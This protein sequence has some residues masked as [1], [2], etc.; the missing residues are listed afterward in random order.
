MEIKICYTL[1][2]RNLLR[3]KVPSRNSKIGSFKPS[4]FFV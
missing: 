2:H 4:F 1:Q 3:T